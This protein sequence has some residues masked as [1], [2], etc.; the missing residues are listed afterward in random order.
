MATLGA[1]E[2]VSFNN[3]LQPLHWHVTSTP[4]GG[5]PAPPPCQPPSWTASWLDLTYNYVDAN[6]HNNGNL[7]R[8]FNHVYNYWSQNFAYDSLNRLATAQ[9]DGTISSGSSNCWAETYTIDAW[10]NLLNNAPNPTTQSAYTGCAQET[11]S[12]LTGVVGVNNRLSGFGYTTD[13]AGNLIADV[14][15]IRNFR[16]I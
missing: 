4:Y 7:V 14:S 1:V 2:N 8:I 9:T 12:N 6:G 13:S 16:L 5:N 10:G 15:P 11:P 3:R